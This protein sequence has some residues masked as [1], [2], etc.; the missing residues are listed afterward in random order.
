[1]G[2]V[3]GHRRDSATAFSC[4]YVG[5]TH[6]RHSVVA[7]LRSETLKEAHWVFELTPF[8]DSNSGK[9]KRGPTALARIAL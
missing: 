3:T 8:Q 1:M 7:S 4:R 6:R 5:V 2:Q 9:L